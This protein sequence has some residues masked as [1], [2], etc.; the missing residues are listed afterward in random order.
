MSDGTK[1]KYT[2]ESDPDYEVDDVRRETI[3]VQNAS[4]DIKYIYLNEYVSHNPQSQGF[5]I[6][7]AETVRSLRYR[8]L[9]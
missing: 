5:S 6:A 2:S 3:A 1:N 7:Q 9:N 4:P 8:G